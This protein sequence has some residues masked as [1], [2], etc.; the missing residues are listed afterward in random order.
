[1][2][3]PLHYYR[4][5]TRCFYIEHKMKKILFVATVYK[6]LKFEINDM[7]ILNEMGYKLYSATNMQ[8]EDWLRDDGFLDSLDLNKKHVEFGR[9]PFSK[10]NILAYKMIKEILNEDFVLIHC[11]TPVAAAITRLAAIKTRKKGTKIIYTS[12]GFHFHKKSGLI[13]W[14]LFYPIEYLSA[15]L[16]DMIITIN[17]EDYELIQ[18]FPVKEKRYI[19][20]VGVDIKSIVNKI[21]DVDKVRDRYKIPMDAF[22]IV[23]VGELSKRKNHKVII[24]AI[25]KLSNTDVYYVICGVGKEESNLKEL[26]YKNKIHDRVIFVGQVSHE[27]VINLYKASDVGA[28]PSKIEGLGL[29]GIECL[30]SG[31]PILASNVHGIKDYAIQDVT[32]Q[33]AAA[34]DVEGFA[35]GIYK[36]MTDKD[37]Y[38]SCCQ[39]SIEM[40]YR[41]DLSI[42][43]KKMRENYSTLLL[44]ANKN[45]EKPGD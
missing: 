35:E 39:N 7:R 6:F 26:A 45:E 10:K 13:N 5:G 32:G 41:F 21:V 8:G 42:T 16:C 24:D 3:N 29:A 28:L 44:N 25:S 33:V 30:A 27:E 14:L 38:N 17:K 11:H 37:L 4:K 34:D 43:D 9:S 18:K 12:H 23:S 36:L 1:M 20:G 19:P 22:L 15:Y 2:S 31:K 40:A